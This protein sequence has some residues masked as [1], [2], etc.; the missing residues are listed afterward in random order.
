MNRLIA[1]VADDGAIDYNG[2]VL[3]VDA[4]RGVPRGERV[5]CLIRPETVEIVAANGPVARQRPRR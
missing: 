1:T 4:A 5:L 2:L 3:R